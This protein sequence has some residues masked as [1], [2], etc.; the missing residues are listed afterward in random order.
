M[1]VCARVCVVF[2]RQEEKVLGRGSVHGDDGAGRAPFHLTCD[3]KKRI[4]GEIATLKTDE[5]AS[6]RDPFDH[7]GSFKSHDWYSYIM[8]ALF[9]SS[10]AG[11]PV[12]SLPQL[13]ALLSFEYVPQVHTLLIRALH[14]S[15]QRHELFTFRFSEAA[16]VG[17]FFLVCA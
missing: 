9:S 4:K 12:S 5:Y 6:W 11:L 13:I 7:E 8:P 3:E 15:I 16:H 2:H 10:I 17:N 1:C 14:V